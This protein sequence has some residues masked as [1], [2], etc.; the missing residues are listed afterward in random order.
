[1]AAEQLVAEIAVTV[2]DVDEA[3]ADALC[4]LC[5]ADVVFGQ[6]LKIV[7]TEQ[8]RIIVGRDV[9]FAIEDRMVICDPRRELGLVVG[10]AESSAVGELE[11]DQ[12]I[13]GTAEDFAMRSGER[14][15]KEG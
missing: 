11:T 6:P 10:L 3:K 8:D 13:V 15:E 5:G 12:K 7:I 9:E 2:L 1:E 4:E 14:F